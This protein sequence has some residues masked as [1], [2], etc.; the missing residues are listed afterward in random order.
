MRNGDKIMVTHESDNSQHIYRIN[1]FL[2]VP[3]HGITYMKE[4]PKLFLS[5]HDMRDDGDYSLE[6]FG[7]GN[8]GK[9]RVPYGPNS[10]MVNITV[11]KI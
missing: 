4:K 2:F 6:L 3:D 1:G 9:N 10:Q 7:S 11:E 5:I 8:Y